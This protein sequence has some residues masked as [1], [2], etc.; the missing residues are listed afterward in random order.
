MSPTWSLDE[1]KNCYYFMNKER[2]AQQHL[3]I[4]PG[5]VTERGF[6]THFSVAW[7]VTLPSLGHVYMTLLVITMA[8]YLL[9]DI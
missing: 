4:H 2:E 9:G 1:G 5:S 3:L 6:E 7:A 8:H